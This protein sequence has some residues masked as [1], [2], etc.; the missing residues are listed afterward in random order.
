MGPLIPK[1]EKVHNTIWQN[2][3]RCFTAATRHLMPTPLKVNA[4]TLEMSRLK[5]VVSEYV[6]HI[7][8]GL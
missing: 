6:R 7:R 8:Y 5:V 4:Q 2:M 3:K 1:D